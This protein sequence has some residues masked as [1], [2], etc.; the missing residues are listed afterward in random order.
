M[1]LSTKDIV[2]KY[3]VSRATLHNWKTTKPN[4][5]NLLKNSDEQFDKVRE[6]NIFLD[7]YIKIAN[8][9]IFSL[10][11]LHYIVSLNLQLEDIKDI[12]QLELLYIN[13]STK[14]K[15]QS[16]TFCL[17]I[18]KKLESLNLIEKYIFCDR[19]KALEAKNNTKSKKDEDIQWLQRYFRDFLKPNATL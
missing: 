15:K 1:I 3:E 16:D 6:V 5:Y 14:I 18:Y 17:D 19:L 2:N 9:E 12:E 11:E 8:K 7:S 4:L 10:D 13:T